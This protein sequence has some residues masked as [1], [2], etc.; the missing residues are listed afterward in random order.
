MR[1]LLLRFLGR[2]R[3]PWL[4]ALTAVLFLVDVLVPDLLPWADEILLGA[5]TLL[6]GAWRQRRHERAD[7]ASARQE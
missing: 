7:A 2:L 1:A 4:F 5:L 6:F 3:F